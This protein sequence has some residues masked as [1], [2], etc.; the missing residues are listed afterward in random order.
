VGC[1]SDTGSAAA[2]SSPPAQTR[3]QQRRDQL[4]NAKIR[5]SLHPSKSVGAALWSLFALGVLWLIVIVNAIDDHHLLRFGI[6]PR[7]ARGLV[8]VVVGPLLHANSGQLAGSSI[9]FVVLCWVLL[10]SGLRNFAIV[11]AVVWIGSGL[12]EWLLGDAH[13]HLVGISPVLF[14]WMGYALA[15]AIYSR[16]VRWISIAVVLVLVFSSFFAGLLPHVGDHVSWIGHVA[17]FALGIGVAA[18]LHRRPDKQRNQAST[19]LKA[20]L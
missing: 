1:V 5:P 11:T 16:S 19:D 8:G 17:G 7:E 4:A 12:A 14:G 20:R 15:R 3:K 2:S 9:P 13:S 18:L 6:R 10:W